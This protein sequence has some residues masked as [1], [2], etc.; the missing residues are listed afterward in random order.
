LWSETP[1]ANVGVFRNYDV[2]PDGKSIAA[3]MP[4]K[5]PEAEKVRNHVFFV[6]NFFD[7]VRRRVEAAK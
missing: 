2:S 1:I 6:Q 3:L 7:E 4:V 5:G